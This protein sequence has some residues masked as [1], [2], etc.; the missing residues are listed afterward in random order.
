[1]SAIYRIAIRTIFS[2]L[3]ES[4]TLYSLL[5]CRCMELLHWECVHSSFLLERSAIYLNQ[6][7][8]NAPV[9][10]LLFSSENLFS[11]SSYLSFSLSCLVY[12]SSSLFF[13]SSCMS[14]SL[15]CLSFSLSCSLMRFALLSSF[16]WNSSNCFFLS[17]SFSYRSDICSFYSSNT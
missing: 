1:M 15:S 3:L 13:S 7:H 17:W 10:L 2:S 9:R 12:S 16:F 4:F 6:Y 14:F 8:C 11:S 5:E